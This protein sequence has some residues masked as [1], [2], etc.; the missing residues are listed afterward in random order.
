M[1]DE[2]ELCEAGLVVYHRM[3]H[4]LPTVGLDVSTLSILKIVT[5]QLAE[6]E[7]E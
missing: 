5:V 6:P 3:V 7:L 2:G 4:K 1:V